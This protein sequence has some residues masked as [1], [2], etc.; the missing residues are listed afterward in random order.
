[1]KPRIPPHAQEPG[2]EASAAIA[3]GSHSACTVRTLVSHFRT[4]V[5]ACLRKF[6]SM[7]MAP[8]KRGMVIWKSVIITITVYP[9]QK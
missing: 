5:K 3:G 6:M 8:P 4:K 1:M 2:N 7:D 9:H